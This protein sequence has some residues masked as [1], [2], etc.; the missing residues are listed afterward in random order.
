MSTIMKYK[1][2]VIR[3]VQLFVGVRKMIMGL[4]FMAIGLT[5]LGLKFINGTLFMETSRDVVVAFMATN[6]AEHIA[7]A[8][9]NWSKNKNEKM[10]S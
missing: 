8:I 10:D 5:L 3:T 1:K 7:E 6:L 2:C 9:K 4:I